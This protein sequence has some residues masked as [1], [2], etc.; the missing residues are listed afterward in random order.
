MTRETWGVCVQAR[1]GAKRREK[2]GEGR[3]L[4]NKVKEELFGIFK[5]SLW[6][7]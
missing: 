1:E 2:V 6:A 7:G 5:P 4:K 3:G